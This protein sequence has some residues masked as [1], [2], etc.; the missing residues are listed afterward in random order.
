VKSPSGSGALD[1]GGLT[2]LLD[3]VFLL[4]F[5][6]L[7]LSRSADDTE[8]VRVDLPVVDGENVQGAGPEARV[9]LLIDAASRVRL[10]GDDAGPVLSTREAL[11]AALGSALDRRL[12]EE[13]VVEI[14]ADALAR[15]GVAVELL[16]HL[17]LA[18]F[19][20]VEL[21]A[22][23]G[24]QAAFGTDATGV[25]AAAGIAGEDGR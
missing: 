15:H 10:A 23:S 7:A 1:L 5:A 8:L 16:Q 22:I 18:G 21:L 14:Q 19:S 25:E 2:P 17:R 11:D 13:V 12:P 9:V 6:L 3:T 24:A 4:I 20:R